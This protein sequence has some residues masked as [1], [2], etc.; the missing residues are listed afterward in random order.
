MDRARSAAA[1]GGAHQVR[2]VAIM[3]AIALASA[4]AAARAADANVPS[5]SQRAAQVI[6][7]TLQRHGGDVHRCFE[8][9]L[10][11]RLDV[12]GNVEVE[13]EVGN[14]GKVTSAR[15]LP[16]DADADA[17]KLVGSDLSDCLLA[18]A[19]TWE[20][21]GIEV[22][23]AV[24][25]PFSFQ[26]QASQFVVKASDVPERGPGVGKRNSSGRVRTPPFTVKVLADLVNVHAEQ[27]SLT[28]LSV[29]PASRVAMHRHPRSAKLLFLIKGKARLLGPRGRPPQKMSEGTAVFVPPG[30]PHVIENMGRQKKAVFLQAFAPPGPERV[31]RDPRD[32][33]GRA[34][35][36]VIRD[37]ARAKLPPPANGRLVARDVAEVKPVPILG[38]KGTVRI[39]VDEKSTGRRELAV[40]F[41]EISPGAE[42]SVHQHA[43][44]TELLYILSGG[45]TLTLDNEKHRFGAAEVL[46]IPAGRSHSLK[47][48][49]DKT[50]AIQIYAPAGPEQNLLNA[51]AGAGQ[52]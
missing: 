20:F 47:F 45:G 50:S 19:T 8:V 11:D 36:E 15:A 42:L 10:A 23:A 6:E 28:V 49:G 40:D 41:L 1:R 32:P 44:T 9:A 21:E 22:G 31:Y 27:V 7:R 37:A 29:G 12:A 4:G 48:S 38:G 52:K 51:P 17:D 43:G 25:L 24:V 30:Y 46:H 5:E 35:F 2:R 16:A 26:G 14:G 33:Q 13:V 18:S 3:T 39:L 34:D